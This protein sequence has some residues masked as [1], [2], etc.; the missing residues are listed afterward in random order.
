M[1]TLTIKFYRSVAGDIPSYGT[2]FNRFLDNLV[3]GSDRWDTVNS[4]GTAPIP[5][6]DVQVKRY[7]TGPEIIQMALQYL[8][9]LVTALS[10]L[11]VAWCAYSKRKAA[12]ERTVKLSW[13]DRSY[14]GPIE[15]ADHA[16]QILA[17]LRDE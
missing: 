5:G 7:E 8:P 14:E 12:E 1:D 11:M 15:S 2:D 13:G 10:G 16:R 4:H 6:T 3:G 9:E 17:M